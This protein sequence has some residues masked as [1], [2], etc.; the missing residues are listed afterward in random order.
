MKRTVLLAAFLSGILGAQA[1]KPV[2]REEA[3]RVAALVSLDLK[4]MLD[5]P[6]PTDP[7]TKRPVALREGERGCLVLPET[8]LADALAKP[9]KEVVPVGQL[10]LRQVAPQANGETVQAEKLKTV[11]ISV[12]DRT[13]S[14]VLCALGLRK[15]ARGE[16]ELLVYG[17]DKEPLVRVPAKTIS[18]KQE[19]PIELA[20]VIEGD[21]ATLT[22]KLAGR[23]EATVRLAGE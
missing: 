4:Q 12:G 5:T 9:G 23:Y 2:P 18:A 13:E 15:L 6:I 14:A 17:K 22:L 10:W 8:R 7:D 20:A 21:N 1:Q 16:L 3:L 11:S 19:N